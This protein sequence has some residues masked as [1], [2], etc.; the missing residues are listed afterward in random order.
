MYEN[1]FLL[2]ICENINAKILTVLPIP[3][4]DW[5]K[6]YCSEAGCPGA[7]LLRLSLG[8]REFEKQFND[9]DFMCNWL[10]VFGYAVMMMGISVTNLV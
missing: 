3:D 9:I 1:V 7:W 4:W 6:I 8:F 10:G 5:E 2:R